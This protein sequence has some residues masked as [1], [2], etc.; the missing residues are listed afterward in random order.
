MNSFEGAMKQFIYWLIPV[1]RMAEMNSRIL[2]LVVTLTPY[3]KKAS[4]YSLSFTPLTHSILS[5]SGR[6]GPELFPQM[7]QGQDAFQNQQ[8]QF[9]LPDA[10]QQPLAACLLGQGWGG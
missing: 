3:R 9:D 5:L 8:E 10:S 1:L 4:L 7:Q 2:S 6:P